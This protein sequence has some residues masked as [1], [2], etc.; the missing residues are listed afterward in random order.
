MFVQ[1]SFCANLVLF[2]R[3]QMGQ[4]PSSSTTSKSAIPTSTLKEEGHIG[5]DVVDKKSDHESLL[6]DQFATVAISSEFTDLQRDIIIAELPLASRLNRD[7]STRRIISLPTRL[8]SMTNTKEQIVPYLPLPLIDIVMSYVSFGVIDPYWSWS[9]LALSQAHVVLVPDYGRAQIPSQ[10]VTIV[11]SVASYDWIAA[12][13]LPIII[14]AV[15][16]WLAIPS[17]KEDIHNLPLWSMRSGKIDWLYHIDI[18]VSYDIACRTAAST[19]YSSSVTEKQQQLPRLSPLT[20][21]RC[22]DWMLRAAMGLTQPFTK[23][24]IDWITHCYPYMFPKQSATKTLA[25]S[26]STTTIAVT[27]TAPSSNQQEGNLLSTTS[28]PLPSSSITPPVSPSTG[29][30]IWLIHEFGYDPDVVFNHDISIINSNDDGSPLAEYHHQRHA[31]LAQIKQFKALVQLSFPTVVWRS[32]NTP[33]TAAPTHDQIVN[34]AS[35]CIVI[36]SSSTPSLNNKDGKAAASSSIG[37]TTISDKHREELRQYSALQTQRSWYRRDIRMALSYGIS[38]VPVVLGTNIFT[39]LH[40][41]APLSSIIACHANGD[42][43]PP[44]LFAHHTIPTSIGHQQ[45]WI[46][47]DHLF[48][49][50]SSSSTSS[51]LPSTFDDHGKIHV[52]SVTQQ[53]LDKSI[54]WSRLCTLIKSYDESLPFAFGRALRIRSGDICSLRCMPTR[55]S[56]EAG[57]QSSI[58]S[59]IISLSCGYFI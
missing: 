9:S 39:Y 18:Q 44:E 36:V 53:A 50:S 46:R 3:S 16:P 59:Q 37:S 51:F 5:S 1:F 43:I 55:A 6:C 48:T 38:I 33:Y 21:Q 57:L 49:P 4:S 25:T 31:C 30:I 32:G 29:P 27:S 20:Y 24:H 42:G 54:D 52:S 19:W 58:S 2:G 40:S 15:R 17:Q 12:Q 35:C 22:E 26:A 28:S 10:E 7:T 13:W 8:Q 47:L 45:S 14:V 56:Y 11:N 23:K 41:S 34:Q